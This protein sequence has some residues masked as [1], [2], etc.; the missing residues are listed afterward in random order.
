[1]NCCLIFVVIIA[2]FLV[3]GMFAYEWYEAPV[4]K[5]DS[6]VNGTCQLRYSTIMHCGQCGQCSNTQDYNVYYDKKDTLTGIAKT[7]AINDIFSREAAKNCFD[8]TAGLTEGCRDCWLENVDCDKKHCM[9]PCLWETLFD[10][11]QNK[12]KNTLS[13]CF[14]CD[15]YYCLD[16]FIKCA[17]MSRRRAGITTD[18]DRHP[19]EMCS[20]IN[21]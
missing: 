21:T 13:K 20:T 7:C 17:G 19:T 16:I 14:A 11:K 9:F 2:I 5:Y 6:E 4:Y 1:M 12:D 3:I 10:I 15:E 8:D 18:I